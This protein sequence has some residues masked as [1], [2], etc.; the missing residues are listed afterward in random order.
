MPKLDRTGWTG[1]ALI[2]SEVF[3]AF[4]ILEARNDKGKLIAKK[5]VYLDRFAKI[6]GSAPALFSDSDISNAT[7][8]SCKSGNK[9]IGFQ[10]NGDGLFLDA[11]PALSR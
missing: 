10:L 1:I 6:L 7:Y 9:L 5:T 11:L 2:N 8:V 3:P 4:V